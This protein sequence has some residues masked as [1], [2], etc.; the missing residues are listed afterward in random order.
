MGAVVVLVSTSLIV[1]LFV[2]VPDGAG[3][4]PVAAVRIQLKLVP[5]VALVAV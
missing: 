1:A 2:A 5:P 4:M 3:V